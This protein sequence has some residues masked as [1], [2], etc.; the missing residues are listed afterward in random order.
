MKAYCA[1]CGEYQEAF[2]VVG[3]DDV[4]DYYKFVC[5]CLTVVEFYIRKEVKHA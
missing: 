2:E 1:K 3:W 5:P 4:N